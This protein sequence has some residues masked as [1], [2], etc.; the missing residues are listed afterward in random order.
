MEESDR[1]PRRYGHRG[2][3]ILK[4]TAMAFAV[5]SKINKWDLLKSQSFCKVKDTLNKTKW[6]PTD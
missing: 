5:R 2:K 1:N 6:P 4:K 3:K